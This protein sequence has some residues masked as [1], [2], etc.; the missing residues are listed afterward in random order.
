MGALRK[1]RDEQAARAAELYLA[2][3][4]VNA[5]AL[6]MKRSCG[7]IAEL[8]RIAGVPLRV[9]V[10]RPSKWDALDEQLVALW[11]QG[12]SAT[13]IAKRL[14]A[15]SRNAVLGRLHRLK[16]AS[17]AVK[18]SRPTVVAVK[19]APK[20]PKPPKRTKEPKRQPYVRLVEPTPTG[21]WNT[22]EIKRPTRFTED[23]P[24]DHPHAKHWT[25]RRFGE[26]AFPVSGRG[27]DV[28]SCAAPARGTYC[29]HHRAVM[30]Q[31]PRQR[32]VRGE[33]RY[34]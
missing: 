30:Y 28:H 11:A 4:T 23:A 1:P 20:A 5:V 14:G 6:E 26:C 9:P 13:V 8:L 17:G 12:L 2:G 3:A 18:P 19:K 24:G 27:A 15:S 32:P 21:G 16:I 7:R 22:G 10:G 29:T 33:R 25:E 34:G 31:P